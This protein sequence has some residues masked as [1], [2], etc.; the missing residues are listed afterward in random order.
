MFKLF[1]NNLIF[2]IFLSTTNLKIPF[3]LKYILSVFHSLAESFKQNLQG[4]A[5]VLA[6][7]FKCKV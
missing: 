7:N 2:K 1:V 6:E 3:F 5:N 4:F